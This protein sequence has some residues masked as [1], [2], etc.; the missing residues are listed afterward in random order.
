MEM[1]GERNFILKF[2]TF[3]KHISLINAD[4]LWFSCTPTL[5]TKGTFVKYSKA[6]KIITCIKY[7][8]SLE[9]A[10]FYFNK[11]IL[12]VLSSEKDPAKIRFIR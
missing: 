7:S 11:T 9:L 2:V 8:I 1:G 4:P 12:K 6:I 5:Y 10:Q 3:I